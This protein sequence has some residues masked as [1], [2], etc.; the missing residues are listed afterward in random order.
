MKKRKK[1]AREYSKLFRRCCATI[2]QLVR[3]PEDKG[4]EQTP[5]LLY[6]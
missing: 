2:N 4:K 1:Q 5:A 6:T 3:R